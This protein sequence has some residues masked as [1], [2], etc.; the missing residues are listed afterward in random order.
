MSYH[1][2]SN[3]WQAKNTITV[4]LRINK[5]QDPEIFDLLNRCS[6]SKSAVIRELIAAGMKQ[7]GK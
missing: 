3:E 1:K 2:S 7:S 5:N 6:G 4:S